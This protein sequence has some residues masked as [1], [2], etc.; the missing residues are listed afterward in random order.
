M[1]IGYIMIKSSLGDFYTSLWDFNKD[2]INE[3]FN[4][5]INNI[6]NNLINSGVDTAIIFYF[7][8]YL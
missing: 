4:G 5:V 3:I 7:P 8:L 6:I 1:L 2:I